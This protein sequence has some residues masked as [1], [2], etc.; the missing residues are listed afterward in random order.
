MYNVYPA[1]SPKLSGEKISRFN[2]LIQFLNFFIFRNK[3]DDRIPGYYFAYGYRYCFLELY[4]KCISINK[5]IENVYIDT[6]SVLP[7]YN[8]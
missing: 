8:A 5:R 3:T 2:F 6:E 1:F 4:F 7:M